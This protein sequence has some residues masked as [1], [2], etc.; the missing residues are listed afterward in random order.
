MPDIVDFLWEIDSEPVGSVT[1]EGAKET[2]AS[3]RILLE[4]MSSVRLLINS[5]SKDGNGAVWL[6]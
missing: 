4:T 5:R 2:V 1:G 3:D 6:R